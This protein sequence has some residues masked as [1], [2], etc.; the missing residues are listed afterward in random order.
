MNLNLYRAR[1]KWHIPGY[2]CEDVDFNVAAPDKEAA[3]NKI[4]EEIVSIR[5]KGT[6]AELMSIE[7][8][9]DLNVTNEMTSV[10]VK[11]LTD[12]A[13]APTKATPGSAGLDLYADEDTLIQPYNNQNI[14][15]TGVAFNIPKGWC[16]QIWPR[17][18]MDVKNRV[19][20]RLA[21]CV[22]RGAGLIDSDYRGEI[23]V[24]LINRGAVQYAIKRGD[25]IAQI[26]IARYLDTEIEVID[27][28]DET[29]R[30]ENG[31]GSSGR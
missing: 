23:L 10:K 14:I 19:S 18:G 31:F 11:L 29:E 2:F 30:G 28:F 6:G 20:A 25:R 3:Q 15:H 1:I 24:L 9:H 17:S 26:L 5:N 16:G 13:K 8:I 27:E 7:L 22:D 4:N 21:P 12:T